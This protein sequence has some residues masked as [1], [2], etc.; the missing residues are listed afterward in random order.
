MLGEKIGETTG[1]V[2]VRRVLGSETGG[3]MVE[4]SFQTT[5][6]LLAYQT[7]GTLLATLAS[8]LQGGRA[9]GGAGDPNFHKTGTGPF[10]YKFEGWRE[11]FSVDWCFGDPTGTCFWDDSGRPESGWGFFP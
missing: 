2:I 3:P 9:T 6:K 7:D 8:G 1:K 10:N 11:G 5:G 4:V